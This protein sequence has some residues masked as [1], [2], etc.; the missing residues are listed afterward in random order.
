MT[1]ILSD[2]MSRC[3]RPCRG[4]LAALTCAAVAMAGCGSAELSDLGGSQKDSR[5]RDAVA[6]LT[7]HRIR[8]ARA[9]YRSILDRKPDSG[10]AAAG[11]ALTELFLLPEH[12]ASAR[13]LKE[14]LGASGEIDAERALYA[15]NGFFYWWARGARWED[16]RDNYDGIKSLIADRLP[17]SRD[18][19]DS[20]Q[21]FFDGLDRPLGEAVG[22]VLDIA[23]RLEQI[24]SDLDVALEDPNLDRFVVPGEVF[25]NRDLTSALGKPEIALLAAGLASIRAA[26]HFGAAYAYEWSLER[27]F[28]SHWKQKADT[29]DSKFPTAWDYSVDFVGRH[30]LTS[31]NE[32]R[33]SHLDRARRA[34]REALGD[35][36][37]GLRRGIES[38]H[39]T[40]LRWNE[41]D[42]AFVSKL[43][44]FVGALRS[45]LDEENTLPHT[46]PTTRA[47]F[48]VLFEEGRTLTEGLSWFERFTAGTQGGGE[49]SG[50]S[51]E[52]EA[53]WRLDRRAIHDVFVAGL[54]DPPFDFTN[55]DSIPESPVRGDRF[56]AFYDNLTGALR[57]RLQGTQLKR[58]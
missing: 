7:G 44:A 16:D 35:L 28:G 8:E 18:R 55:P 47:D 22:D 41:V 1:D 21:T 48:S 50:S 58:R 26:I 23:A 49:G 27:A 29:P 15:R 9:T 20:P 14:H 11:L 57:R 19:L 31:L 54:F 32:Q 5:L 51:P 42:P 12:Q 37:D 30:L 2:L 4:W 52:T 17:W 36:R 6:A 43:R 53:S 39:E 33:R 3:S 38:E 10:E 25:F 40:T 45:A 56:N 34:L 46:D 24:E 13:L